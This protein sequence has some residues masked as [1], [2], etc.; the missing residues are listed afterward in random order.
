MKNLATI[1]AV[2]AVILLHSSP[3]KALL[4][5]PEEEVALTHRTV[6]RSGQLTSYSRE[7]KSTKSQ[8]SIWITRQWSGNDHTICK[9]ESH[10]QHLYEV[11]SVQDFADYQQGL[12]QFRKKNPGYRG[13]AEFD[14]PNGLH[15][16]VQGSL[17][18]FTAS[19]EARDGCK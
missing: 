13:P 17:Q 12:R 11:L 8:K 7:I 16:R 2:T 5:S 1:L 15:V 6:Q 18:T 9:V 3:A 10:G 4:G 19:A 14:T